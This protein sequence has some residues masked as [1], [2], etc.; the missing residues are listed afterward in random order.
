M[1]LYM[2]LKMYHSMKKGKATN[3]EDKCVKQKIIE[4]VY[5]EISPFCK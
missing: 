5:A 1:Q 2:R 4:G 3:A